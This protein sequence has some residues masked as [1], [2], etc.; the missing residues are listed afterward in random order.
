MFLNIEN[1]T[2]KAILKN[3]SAQYK[4]YYEIIHFLKAI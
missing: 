2:L 4:V 1:V 3:A